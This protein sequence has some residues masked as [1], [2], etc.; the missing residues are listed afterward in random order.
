MFLSCN[1][2]VIKGTGILGRLH[3]AWIVAHLSRVLAS[4]IWSKTAPDNFGIFRFQLAQ[5]AKRGRM[6]YP[7]VRE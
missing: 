2:L 1:I 3:S 4:S 7:L 6:A 5:R